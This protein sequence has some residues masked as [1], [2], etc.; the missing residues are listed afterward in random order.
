MIK[1]KNCFRLDGNH[2]KTTAHPVRF[3]Q[4]YFELQRRTHQNG[5][6]EEL[7]EVEYPHT[8]ARV[9]SYCDVAD[10]KRD[11]FTA[12]T[13]GKPRV[14]LGDVRDIQEVVKMDTSERVAYLKGLRGAIDKLVELESEPTEKPTEKPTENPT[15]GGNA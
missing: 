14:N 10:Y 9:N 1:L 3:G 8:P 6:S 15:E 7:V 11:P 2:E 4:T 5:V 13:N 12:I